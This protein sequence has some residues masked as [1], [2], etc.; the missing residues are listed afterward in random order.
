MYTQGSVQELARTCHF[1]QDNQVQH[2]DQN[3]T[4]IHSHSQWKLGKY[5]QQLK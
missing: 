5:A 4:L 1:F 3:N 2:V